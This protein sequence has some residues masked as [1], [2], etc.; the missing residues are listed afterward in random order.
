MTSPALPFVSPKL[1]DAA[2]HGN[3]VNW[4]LGRRSEALARLAVR[5][6]PTQR[7]EDWRYTSLA[8]LSKAEL[9]PPPTSAGVGQHDIDALIGPAAGTRWVFVDGRLAR[10]LSSKVAAPGV[11]L[12]DLASAWKAGNPHVESLWTHL[13]PLDHPVGALNAALAVDGAFIDIA[14]GAKPDPIQLVFFASA[15]GEPVGSFPRVLI[16]AGANSRAQVSQVFVGPGAAST[17]TAAVTE[18]ALGARAELAVCRVQEEGAGATHLSLTS[19]VLGGDA[20]L[21]SFV[22]AWGAGLA[23][24]EVTVRLKTPGA[25]CELNGLYVGRGN[26]HLDHHTLIDHQQ[27]AC[28]SRELYKGVLF[29]RAHG[30]FTGRV[31]VEPG[32]A[33]TDSS[34]T[35]KCLLLSDDALVDARPQLEIFNDDVKCT[36]GSAVGQLDEAALFY[37]RSRGIGPLAAQQMLTTAFVAEVLR[38]VPRDDWRQWLS[39]RVARHLEGASSR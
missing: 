7:D 14:P 34:Q 38:A 37:L 39:Q 18:L 23:R 30:V 27:G 16:S 25:R 17:V 21:S 22:F 36:H 19:A 31:R 3:A 13:A 9:A 10:P 29:D 5:G 12:V 8:R 33:K 24:D 35:H 11:K 6:L 2:L 20:R 1:A 26:Q 28:T 32:A 15:H 4:V